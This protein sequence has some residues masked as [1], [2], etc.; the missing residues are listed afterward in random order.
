ML[1]PAFLPPP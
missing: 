1:P